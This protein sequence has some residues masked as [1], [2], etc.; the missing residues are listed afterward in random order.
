LR[1]YLILLLVFVFILFL[2]S[3]GLSDVKIM[4]IFKNIDAMSKKHTPP[5]YKVRVENQKFSDALQELPKEILTGEGTPSVSIHFHKG[6]GIKIVIENIDSEYASIFSYIEDYF[7]FSGISKVQNP[8]EFKEFIDNDKVDFYK[9]EKD[10]VIVKAWDPENDVKDDNYALFYLDKKNWVI[11]KAVYYLDGIP[12]VQ[13][14][15]SYKSFGNYYMPYKIVLTSVNEN[16]SDVFLF[17]D[18]QFFK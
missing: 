11:K 10:F 2:G 14:D 7:K 1:K 4:E 15:N 6:E 16:T 13:A 18:Y 17:K 3:F 5:S 12:F 9:E 8:V